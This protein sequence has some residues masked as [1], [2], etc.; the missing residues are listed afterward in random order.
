MAHFAHINSENIVDNVIVADQEF[1]DSGYVGNPAEWLQTSYNTR[2]GIHYQPDSDIPSDDQ[3]KALRKNYAGIDYTYD[4]DRDAFIPPKPYESWVLGG[5]SC[6]W[7]PPIARPADGKI[8][9]WDDTT[10]SWVEVNHWQ[11]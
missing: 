4:K 2:S 5:F 7:K 3:S 1:I 10:I 11:P 6:N 8:Y 9:N